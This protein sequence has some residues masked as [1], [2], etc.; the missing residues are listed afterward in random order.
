MQHSADG[1]YLISERKGIMEKINT[2][3]TSLYVLALVQ[4]ERFKESDRGDTNFV[5]MILIIGIAVALAA[6]FMKFGDTIMSKI[7]SMVTDFLG[8]LNTSH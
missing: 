5:S 8:S 7:S 6:T 4:L 1:I 3:I 2:V